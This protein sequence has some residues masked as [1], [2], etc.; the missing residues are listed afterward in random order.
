MLRP[1]FRTQQPL[2]GPDE[3]ERQ[4]DGDSEQ[5]VGRRILAQLDEIVDRQRQESVSY[6][7][8]CL[9]AE[10]SLRILPERARKASSAPAIIPLYASGIVITKKILSEEAPRVA[11]ICSNRGF[12]SAKEVRT[13]RTKSGKD[14]TAMA[15]STPFQLKTISMPRS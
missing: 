8:Y 15:M 1:F 3:Q 9:P 4:G 7:G 6:P 10:L 5:G 2:R 11:A 14:I 13:D 12:T